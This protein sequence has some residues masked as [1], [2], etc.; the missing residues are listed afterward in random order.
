MSYTE[1]DQFG[2]VYENADRCCDCGVPLAGKTA[3]HFD[4]GWRC[5]DCTDAAMVSDYGRV[6]F[7]EEGDEQL[8]RA[9]AAEARLAAAKA[10][11]ADYETILAPAYDD[12]LARIRAA[13]DAEPAP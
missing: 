9:N 1:P 3:T 2:R 4:D 6:W 7:L 12:F 10:V 5:E 11:V 8:A 13:F